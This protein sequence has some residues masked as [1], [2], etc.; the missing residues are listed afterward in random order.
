MQGCFAEPYA[1]RLGS[2]IDVSRVVVVA[3]ATHH[4]YLHTPSALVKTGGASQLLALLH[5]P[6][7]TI[8]EP[9]YAVVRIW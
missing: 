7:R 8:W 9:T 2:V 5:V 6:F 1:V 3:A 4:T